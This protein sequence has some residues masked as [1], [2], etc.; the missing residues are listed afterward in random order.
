[1]RIVLYR[2]D[3]TETRARYVERAN[4]LKTFTYSSYN[5]RKASGIKYCVD[6]TL[7]KIVGIG[8]S[9]G[10]IGAWKAYCITIPRS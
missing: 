7:N 9:Y 6:S 10:I 2:Y 5:M 8:G 3:N 4:F 1:M